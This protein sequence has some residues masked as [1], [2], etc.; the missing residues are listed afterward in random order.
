M[1]AASNQVAGHICIVCMPC[2]SIQYGSIQYGVHIA[3][4]AYAPVF[5][6]SLDPYMI[7]T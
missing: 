4:L 2:G 7:P 6:V 5:A 1:W 3:W